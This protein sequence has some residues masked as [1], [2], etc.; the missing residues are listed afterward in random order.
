VIDAG[1]GLPDESV[2]VTIDATALAP[3]KQA[4][5]AAHASQVDNADLA[6]MDA[7]LFQLLFGREFY[8]LGW[9]RRS[10]PLK[11]DDLF[12]GLLE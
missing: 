5:I 8:V 6:T 12:G 3:A 4:S 11:P 10:L 2:D 9:S 7:D 1:A